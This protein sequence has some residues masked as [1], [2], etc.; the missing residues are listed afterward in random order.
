MFALVVLLAFAPFGVPVAHSSILTTTPAG[1]DFNVETP[2][3][4]LVFDGATGGAGEIR[5]FYN[6]IENPAFNKASASTTAWRRYLLHRGEAVAIPG[7]ACSSGDV[8]SQDYENTSIVLTLVEDT[9]TRAKLQ[10]DLTYTN[11]VTETR[12]YHVYP[13]GKLYY[14]QTSNSTD[15]YCDR[16]NR[17]IGTPVQYTANRGDKANRI[18]A[19]VDNG[20]ITDLL[21][22]WFD[23]YDIGIT[24]DWAAELPNLGEVNE[25]GADFITAG[26]DSSGNDLDFPSGSYVASHLFEF[27]NAGITV[28]GGVIGGHTGLMDDYRT[29]AT[30][31]FAIGGGDGSQVGDGFAE[32]RGAYTLD[33]ADADDHVKFQLTIGGFTRFT[34]AFEITN[35]NSARPDII[36]VDGVLKTRGVDYNADVVGTTL[37]LQY[38]SDLAADTVFEIG[39]ATSDI[40]GTVFE[41]ANFAG[42][43]SDWDGGVSDAAQAN[44]DVELYDN[45][46]VYIT[47]TTTNASGNYTFGGLADGTY[48][49]RVRSATIGDSNTPP[50]GG[51]NGACAITD[52]PSGP[53]CVLAEQTWG[54]GTALYGGQSATVDDT[55]TNND[56]GPGDNYV[57]VTI[58]GANVPT[59]NFGFAYNLIVNT[60]DSGQGSLRQFIENANAIGTAGGTTANSSEFRMQVPANESAGADTWW[61]ITVSSALPALN[62]AG[63]VLD[64]ATQTSNGGDTN[65]GEFVHPF[66]GANKD[67]G[68]GPDGVEGTGD[69]LQLPSYF[70]PEI[71]IDGN[72]QGFILEIAANNTTVKR[73]ALFNS[74]ASAAIEV[75]SGSGSLITDNFIGVRAEG[76][77]PGVGARIN[78]A[79][80]LAGQAD[81][82]DNLI[83]LTEDIALDVDAAST[84]SGNEIYDVTFGNANDDGISVENTT[85]QPITITRN[86]IDRIPGYGIESWNGTGPWTIDENTISRTGQGSGGNPG[87]EDGGIRIFGTG[88]T[89]RHNIVTSSAGA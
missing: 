19:V 25:T 35:W 87:D 44:V 30:L 11:G 57:S 34:P 5:E 9:G 12:L 10:S 54:N 41:D 50:M 73:L 4:Q 22:I 48:K 55:A 83:A 15:N 81:I 82:T 43:A 69:E 79:V 80:H 6:K 7:P 33:D 88:S 27:M 36:L 32:D 23:N 85:G 64:G 61:R 18:A 2:E 74:S 59:V 75:S 76:T 38:L 62:D 68:T 56:A 49:V 71:E 40:S 17:V 89:V 67:V 14:S 86:R 26:F 84:I 24:S 70:H 31:D 78:N 16:W 39:V 47:S 20:P 37:I 13:T 28:A 53:P 65:L 51:F 63:T 45:L 72:D 42:T 58:S 21:Q 66:Y 1:T 8:S 77:D 60:V 3:F 29:P 52:P 46:D